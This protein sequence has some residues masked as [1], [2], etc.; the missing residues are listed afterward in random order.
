VI[1]K[2]L[3]A[4]DEPDS[5]FK[6]W[7]FC[8]EKVFGIYLIEK[9][10]HRTYFKISTINKDL[11]KVQKYNPVGILINTISVNFSIGKIYLITE[12]NQWATCM[13]RFG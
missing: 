1:A 12:A 10:K 6:D 8:P 9:V 5:V 2:N 4:K 3:H 7:G 13:I 11:V